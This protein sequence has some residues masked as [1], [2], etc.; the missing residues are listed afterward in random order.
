[1]FSDLGFCTRVEHGMLKILQERLIIV[2]WSKIHGLY[3]L[4]G[5]NFIGYASATS[6]YF[7]DFYKL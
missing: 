5:S 4:H 7:H 6:E 2:K 3:I 1:M